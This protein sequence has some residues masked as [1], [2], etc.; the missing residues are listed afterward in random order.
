MDSSFLEMV[1]DIILELKRANPSLVYGELFISD[2]SFRSKNA[3][4]Q[5][6]EVQQTPSRF[7]FMAASGRKRAPRLS[8]I[9]AC[10]GPWNQHIAS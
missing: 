9:M 1:V 3:L 6:N 5:A 4:I 2:S 8:V 7:H 10:N